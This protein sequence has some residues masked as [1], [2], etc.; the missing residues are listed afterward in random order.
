MGIFGWSMRGMIM[1][2]LFLILLGTAILMSNYGVW[3]FPF[4]LSRDWPMI[5]IGWG[6][7]KLFDALT[8]AGRSWFTGGS[9]KQP[10]PKDYRKI[11]DDLVEGRISGEE[12][13][14]DMEE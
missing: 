12:A 9:K 6:I 11:V 3:M 8:Y 14:R 1:W 7:L 10:G 5:L 4:K 2:G 13:I